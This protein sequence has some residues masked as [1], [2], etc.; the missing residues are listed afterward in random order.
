MNP[1]PTT[2]DVPTGLSNLFSAYDDAHWETAVVEL[3][4]NSGVLKR[5][6][7]LSAVGGKLEL[8]TS[9]NQ[10]TAF[11]VLLDEAVDTTVPY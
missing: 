9:A 6:S 5:G 10:A 2:F 3:K 8:V 1:N 4:A 11:G 7:V